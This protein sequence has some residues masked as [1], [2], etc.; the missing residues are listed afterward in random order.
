MAQR[1]SLSHD[2]GLA[3]AQTFG[4]K[5]SSCDYFINAGGINRWVM[6][7]SEEKNVNIL[8]LVIKQRKM[9]IRILTIGVDVLVNLSNAES[10]QAILSYLKFIASF[11]S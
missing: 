3:H 2:A 10:T 7:G 5:L 9:K 8:A 4:R 11:L 1:F 6:S